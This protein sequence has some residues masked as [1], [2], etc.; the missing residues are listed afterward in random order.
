MKIAPARAAAFG[1]LLKLAESS[2][3]YSDDLLRSPQVNALSAPD[4]HLATTLVMGVLRW[5]LLLDV[6]IGSALTNRKPLDAV[7]A[8]ALRLGLFQLFFL[9]RIPA[10]AAINDSVELAKRNGHG[11]ASGLVNAVLRK[12]ATAPRPK[13]D[14]M[15]AHP[16]WLVKRWSAN[17]GAEASNAIC[18]YDQQPPPTAIRVQGVDALETE[19]ALRQ[20]GIELAP[21]ALLTSAR[22]VTAGDVS[23]TLAR[24]TGRLRIQDEGSQLIAELAGKGS[25]ILDCCA[26]PGGKTAILAERNPDA[27]IVACDISRARLAQMESGFA[28]NRTTARIRCIEAD[29]TALPL[30]GP[31][32]GLFDLILCDAPCTGTGTLARNPEIKLRLAPAELAR[33]HARQLALI[34]AAFSKLASGGRLIYSTC[35]LEPEENETVVERCLAEHAQARLLPV[36]DRLLALEANGVLRAETARILRQHKSTGGFL[37]TF[38]GVL[39]CDGFFA[40]ILTKI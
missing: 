13:V 32:D 3:S 2:S 14:P 15:A 29:A 39:S 19:D 38:P 11:S 9:D 7:I 33:Q 12:L 23:S 1:I 21:G 20:A 31:V 28:H 22:I 5:Q 34:N 18:G 4:R 24:A 35:S 17:F 25:R 37:R 40:A 16:K 6:R 8:I 30:H 26:A 36:E 10:H 27:E